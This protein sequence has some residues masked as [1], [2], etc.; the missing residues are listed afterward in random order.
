MAAWRQKFE[1]VSSGSSAFTLIELL[2]VIAIIA[3]LAST[4]LPSLGKAREVARTT[5][6]MNNQKQLGMSLLMYVDDFQDF[7]PLNG[8]NNWGAPYGGIS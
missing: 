5:A 4:L 6:C 8:D 7:Y 1:K 2:V 3:I